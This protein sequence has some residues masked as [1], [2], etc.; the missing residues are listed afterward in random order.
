MVFLLKKKDAAITN[1]IIKII[2]LKSNLLKNSV[3]QK[4]ILS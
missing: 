1:Y 4:L 2:L 3:H